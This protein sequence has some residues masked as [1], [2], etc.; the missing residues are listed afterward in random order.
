MNLLIHKNY[1]EIF[2]E[3]D[4]EGFEVGGVYQKSKK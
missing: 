4:S 3:I 2:G 1:I